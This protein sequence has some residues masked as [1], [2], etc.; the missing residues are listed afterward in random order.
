LFKTTLRSVEQRYAARP[1][2]VDFL[3]ASF[4][5]HASFGGKRVKYSDRFFAVNRAVGGNTSTRI[6][7]PDDARNDAG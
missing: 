1:F 5:T 2:I 6:G 4:A 3:H 7:V